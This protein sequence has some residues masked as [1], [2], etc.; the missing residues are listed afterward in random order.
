[1]EHHRVRRRASCRPRVPQSVGCP[2]DGK[3]ASCT[4]SGHNSRRRC[5]RNLE[6]LSRRLRPG[7]KVGMFDG[8]GRTRR[9]SPNSE[10]ALRTCV[11]RLHCHETDSDNDEQPDCRIKNRDVPA[12]DHGDVDAVLHCAPTTPDP[13]LHR[14]S[15]MAHIGL[16]IVSA[17]S[18]QFLLAA[19]VPLS[20]LT[21]PTRSP[22]DAL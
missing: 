13:M 10:A 20:I 16:R 6:G 12:A 9:A 1:M 15:P 19:A 22:P 21:R 18:V 3:A 14:P 4:Y 7:L 8:S 17:E 5:R 2:V 11:P